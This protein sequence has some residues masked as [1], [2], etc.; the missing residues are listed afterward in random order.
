MRDTVSQEFEIGPTIVSCSR[1][2]SIQFDTIDD[3]IEHCHR[4]ERSLYHQTVFDVI[5]HWHLNA[6]PLSP[7]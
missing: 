7:M 6:L 5:E 4:S 1:F 3:T 2:L